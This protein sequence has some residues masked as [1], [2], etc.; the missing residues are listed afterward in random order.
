MHVPQSGDHKLAGAVDHLIGGREFHCFRWADSDNVV[1]ADED[2]H[3]SLGFA[4]TRIDD[5]HMSESKAD[6]LR[7]NDIRKPCQGIKHEKGAQNRLEMMG[8]HNETESFHSRWS[9]KN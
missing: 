9:P 3:V 8:L 6:G 5:G 1:S 4:N 7:G 2:G